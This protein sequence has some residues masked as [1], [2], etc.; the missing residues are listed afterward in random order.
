M[1]VFQTNLLP[2]RF[3]ASLINRSIHDLQLQFTIYTFEKKYK[4][5]RLDTVA[6]IFPWT[7]VLIFF[8]SISRQLVFLIDK[9]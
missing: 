2:I 9:N 7:L 3:N 6:I 1:Q 8:K 4:T 5:K